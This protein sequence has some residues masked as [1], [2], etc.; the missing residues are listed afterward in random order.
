MKWQE[1]VR[2]IRCLRQIIKH[3]IKVKNADITDIKGRH[4]AIIYE[5]MT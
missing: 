2:L 1:S 3:V 5:M 4:Q